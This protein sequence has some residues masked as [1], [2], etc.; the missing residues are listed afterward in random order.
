MYSLRIGTQ[1]DSSIR[2]S[3]LAFMVY[4]VASTLDMMQRGFMAGKFKNL[5]RKHNPNSVRLCAQGAIVC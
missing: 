3:A 2:L 5:W 4:V 1:Q